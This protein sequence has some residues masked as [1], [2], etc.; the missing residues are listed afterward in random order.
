MKTIL[1]T[2]GTGLIGKALKDKLISKGFS[3]II[4]SRSKNVSPNSYYWNINKGIIENEAIKKADAIIHLAGAGIADKRWTEKR[5]QEL[6]NS[7]VLSTKLLLKK[8]EELNPN[9]K[10]FIAA[11]GIGYYGANTSE[12]I[13]NEQDE[14]GT[15]FLAT[16]CKLWENE[17]LKFQQKNIRTVILRTGVVLTNK[18][19]ALEKMISPIKMGVGAAL[20]KGNQYMPWIHID[21]L[22]EMYI[23]AIDNHKIKGVYNAVSNMH[24]TNKELTHN[25]AK[26]IHKKIWLPPIPSFILKLLFGEMAIILLKGSR[27]SNKKIIETG[28]NFKYNSIDKCLKNLL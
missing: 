28:F 6:I 10:C 1:I 8:T 24:I 21:D 20:G 27:I 2:G 15:D 5:K 4:L 3:V 12:K 9:L 22:C 16:I 14:S 13:Y 26:A 19:G 23:T 18:G 17:S 25:M 7:R 11:S